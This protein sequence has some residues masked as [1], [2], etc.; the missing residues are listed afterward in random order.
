MV[1]FME[2]CSEHIYINIS[3][4]LACSAA[5]SY[6]S[7][8]IEFSEDKEDVLLAGFQSTV[9][10]TT[11]VQLVPKCE[12]RR[13]GGGSEAS[14]DVRTTKVHL[15]L[16]WVMLLLANVLQQ[17]KEDTHIRFYHYQGRKARKKN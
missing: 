15:P 12:E 8:G 7:G 2:N 13:Q 14:G 10:K 1:N 16:P 3:K 5:A 6:P 9:I 17:L 11:V 4:K